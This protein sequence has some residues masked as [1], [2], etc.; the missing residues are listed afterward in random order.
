[1]KISRRLASKILGIG[2]RFENRL[3]QKDRDLYRR[4]MAIK[5]E[6]LDCVLDDNYGQRLAAEIKVEN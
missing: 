6:V 4:Y 2:R 5:R 1:M 3:W